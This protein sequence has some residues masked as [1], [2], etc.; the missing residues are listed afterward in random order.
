M[1]NYFTKVAK[2]LD[3]K[4]SATSNTKDIEETTKHFDDHISLCKINEAYSEILREDNFNLKMVS[5]EEVK[6]VVLK[7]NS[8]KSSTHGAI[9]ANIIKQ[10]M[11]V[12][13]KD[14]T[15]TINHSLKE[16]ELKQSEVIPVCKK[17]DPL[18]KK[19]YRPVSLL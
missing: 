13:L 16:S 17:V 6:K 5:V 4:P 10:T 19:N 14:V 3:L 1:N 7:L 12:H 9:P 8:K 2:N 15:K 11:E 18:Q